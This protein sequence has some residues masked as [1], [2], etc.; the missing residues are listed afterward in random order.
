MKR[1][2]QIITNVLA[3]LKCMLWLPAIVFFLCSRT[4]SWLYFS[5][6]LGSVL[7]HSFHIPP[8]YSLFP[9]KSPAGV[10]ACVFVW[11]LVCVC[12]SRGLFSSSLWL[13]IACF[14]HDCGQLHILSLL[15]AS[16]NPLRRIRKQRSVH[17]GLVP[18]SL[19]WGGNWISMHT[20]TLVTL[21]SLG[22]LQ[23]HT[24]SS[25]G[26]VGFLFGGGVCDVTCN[27]ELAKCACE[28]FHPFLF[29]VLSRC[30][31][32]R[33]RVDYKKRERGNVW[34]VPHRPD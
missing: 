22:R 33:K 30:R 5:L 18:R 32:S 16:K 7:P 8:T 28:T 17:S 21:L 10:H 13:H 2:L 11:L 26:W 12:S 14:Y 15:H 3:C 6:A 23:P 1:T 9:R 25:P 4:S 27:G 24:W 19:Q 29:L 20:V 34:S 31:W